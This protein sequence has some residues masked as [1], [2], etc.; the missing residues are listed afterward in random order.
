MAGL[1]QSFITAAFG[2]FFGAFFALMT[3][4]WREGRDRKR[5][6]TEAF[7]NEF[8]SANFLQHRIA[9]SRLRSK[10][11]TGDV[12]VESIAKG[13]WYPGL[14]NAYSGETIGEF[15]EH[16]HLT[17]YFGFLVRLAHAKKC[18]QIDT[19]VLTSAIRTSYFWQGDLANAVAIGVRAQA[20]NSPSAELPAW[21]QAV[22]DVNNM[23]AYDFGSMGQL[24]IHE[25]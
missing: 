5:K 17:I 15:N 13:Y 20:K 6:T 25:G 16:Q 4:L 10:V 19:V 12:S 8:F 9:V 7:I 24:A 11:L 1:F 18:K 2:A 21:V 23:L 3:T 22:D 14:E